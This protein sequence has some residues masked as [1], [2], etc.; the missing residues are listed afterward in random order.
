MA[1]WLVDTVSR[2]TN[3]RG[4]ITNKIV[5]RP[6]PSTD[7]PADEHHAGRRGERRPQQSALA[8][9]RQFNVLV[10]RGDSRHRQCRRDNDGT[11]VEQVSTTSGAGDALG[12]RLVELNDDSVIFDEHVEED[13]E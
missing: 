8:E 6:V 4:R 7:H 9:H 10:S 5:C 1:D 3:N 11:Q 12:A 2:P 13:T